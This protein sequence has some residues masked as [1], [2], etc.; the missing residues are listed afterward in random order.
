MSQDT[1]L[2]GAQIVLP[3]QTW[4]SNLGWTPHPVVQ[5]Y[6]FYKIK[7]IA[8]S[9]W[10]LPTFAVVF[11]VSN[12][13]IIA[14]WQV[15]SLP[16]Y[17]Y[18]ISVFSSRLDVLRRAPLLKRDFNLGVFLWI[19]LRIHILKKI[20]ERLLLRICFLVFKLFLTVSITIKFWVLL[21]CFFWLFCYFLFYSSFAINLLKQTLEK[22]FFFC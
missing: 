5:L 7:G 11:V 21:F 20:F 15:Y 2:I 14:I 4:Q 3:D 16:W 1:P 18:A 10:D 19:Y 12:W 22:G 17:D 8:P 6:W 9:F 13:L